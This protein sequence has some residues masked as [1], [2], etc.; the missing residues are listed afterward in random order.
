MHQSRGWQMAK[1][2]TS[3]IRLGSLALVGAAVISGCNMSASKGS[4]SG[5]TSPPVIPVPAPAGAALPSGHPGMD[6]A[7]AMTPPQSGMAMPPGHPAV[8]QGSATMPPHA[9][10][11]LP[12]GHP[13][14]DGG[15]ATMPPGHGSMDLGKAPEVTPT[16]ELDAKIAKMEKTGGS[17]Q[18]LSLLYSERGGARMMDN[19]A[20][21]HVKYRAALQ[22]YRHALKLDPNNKDAANNKALIESI[23]RG[24]GRP[25][26]E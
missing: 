4:A 11:V 19:Q 7:S 15:G 12:S 9:I 14:V 24:M 26:P 10:S 13:G 23:Y 20:S 22:D 21:P 17:K 3:I 18:E 1:P 6:H 5:P 25:I 2:L 16:A 8:D